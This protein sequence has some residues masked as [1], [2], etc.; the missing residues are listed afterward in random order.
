MQNQNIAS[1]S[2]TL[3]VEMR[4]IGTAQKSLAAAQIELSTGKLADTEIALGHR[5]E[6]VAVFQQQISS[7]SERINRN[8][9]VAA[10]L[11]ATEG[12]LAATVDRSDAILQG[13]LQEIGGE[14]SPDGLIARTKSVLAELTTALNT[15][16][17]GV[18]LLS[19]KNISEPPIRYD[20]SRD[21]SPAVQRLNNA[22]EQ[23]F[24]FAPS[25]EQA[26]DISAASMRAFL[27]GPF[28]QLFEGS[29]WAVWSSASDEKMT[30]R[31][32][33]TER[34]QIP[35][36]ANSVGIRSVTSGLAAIAHLGVDAMNS[37]ARNEVFKSAI[38]RLSSGAADLNT[39]RSVVGEITTRLGNDNEGMNAQSV[40]MSKFL[41]EETG[42][43]ATEVAM[44]IAKLTQ[45]I[46]ASYSMIAKIQ[47]L[48]LLDVI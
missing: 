25:S 22:F 15:S 44:R 10:R 20:L 23:T 1:H 24:G 12:V 29:E 14:S 13:V 21:D 9:I 34:L 35:G 2:T 6:A 7:I 42:A 16:V 46:E 30:Y 40:M 47:R 31:L 19:G 43:D 33:A 37:Q 39:A 36:S 4:A 17:D 5:I 32:A 28:Q 26:K 38:T 45:R 3:R 18:H 27:D 48:S 41:D 11:S 8:N